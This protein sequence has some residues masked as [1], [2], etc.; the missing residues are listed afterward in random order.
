MA[1]QVY[2]NRHCSWMPMLALLALGVVAGA[3]EPAASPSPARPESPRQSELAAKEAYFKALYEGPENEELAVQIAEL[4]RERLGLLRERDEAARIAGARLPAERAAFDTALAAAAGNAGDSAELTS[5]SQ[6]RAAAQA[7]LVNYQ[8][9]LNAQPEVA[10]LDK[11]IAALDR[12]LDDLYR[13]RTQ[14]LEQNAPAV[15]AR[16]AELDAILAPASLEPSP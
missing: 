12:R 5:R 16:K 10:A 4:R 2:M 7:A 13:Q 9:A 3:Q 6:S 14:A 15:A 11:R 8:N 1:E